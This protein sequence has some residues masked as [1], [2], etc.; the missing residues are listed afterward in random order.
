MLI[1]DKEA[2]NAAGCLDVNVGQLWDPFTRCGLAHF[3]EHMLFLGTEEFPDES[4]YKK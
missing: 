2:D 1:H 4:E 3:C